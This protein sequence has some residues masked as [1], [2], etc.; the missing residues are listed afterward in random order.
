MAN[1][2]EGLLK[3]GRN[4]WLSSKKYDLFK[5]TK[6]IEEK[7]E[8]RISSSFTFREYA[9]LKKA[10]IAASCNMHNPWTFQTFKFIESIA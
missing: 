9:I 3:K 1:W 8:D 5:M 6:V 4:N 7:I 10:E 2:K